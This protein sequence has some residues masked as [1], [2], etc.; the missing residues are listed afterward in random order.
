MNCVRADRVTV[1]TCRRRIST[2][3]DGETWRCERDRYCRRR[4]VAL[5][6]G[7]GVALGTGLG[8]G[9]RDDDAATPAPTPTSVSGLSGA[10][11][12]NALKAALTPRKVTMIPSEGVSTTSSGSS[13]IDG[14]SLVEV[15]PLD[16]SSFSSTS[17]Y[18]TA[19]PAETFVDAVSSEIFRTPNM[20]LCYIA[21]VNWTANLNTGPY[22]AEIDPFHCDNSDGDRIKGKVTY[23]WVVNATGPDI[24]DASDTRDFKTNVWVALSDTPEMPNIDTEMIIKRDDVAIKSDKI[25]VKNFTF[26]YQSPTGSTAPQLIKGVVRRECETTDADSDCTATGVTWWEEVTRGGNSFTAGAKSRAENDVTKASFQTLDFSGGTPQ[27]QSG[28]LVTTATLVKTDAYGQ[29][30]CD[31]LENRSFFGERYGAYDSNGAKVNLQSYVHLQ[32]TGSDGKT[33][34]ADLHYP[35]NLYIFEYDYI[36]DTALSTAEKTIA[37]A[38][39]TDGS[40][41]EEIVDWDDPILNVNKR[42]KVSRGVLYKFT[43]TVRSA[44][45]YQGA[46][47]TSW[48]WDDTNAA[49]VEV[50]FKYD[51]DA[52]AL[53]LSSRRTWNSGSLTANSI[54]SPRTLTM[55]D[56]DNQ[57]IRCWGSIFGRGSA[58]LLNLTHFKVSDA[59]TVPPGSLSSH[60]ALTCGERCIDQTKLSSANSHD[61][62]FYSSPNGYNDARSTYKKFVFNKDTGSLKEDVSGTLSAEV[63]MD[64]TNPFYATNEVHMTLFEATPANLATLSCGTF[65]SEICEEPTKLDVHYEWSSSNWEGMAWL[66][67]PSNSASK[68]F[69]DPPLQLQG[70][71]PTDAV[72]LR[73]PS[74]TDYSGVNL[75]V[76]YEGG[77]VSDAP[78]V[79][80][81]PMTGDR[82]WPEVDSSGDEDCDYTNGYYRRPDVLI[83][84]GTTFKQ[85]STGDRYVLKLESGVEMLTPADASA[86]SGMSYDTSITVP[87]V[88]DY[89]AFTMPTKPSM[90]GLSVKG[91]DKVS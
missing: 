32:A 78:F 59:Q 57:I 39:F 61:S 49:E 80:F 20:V 37:Q 76:R 19:P 27:V 47:I 23:R 67:D 81:N 24:D 34:N 26:T 85:P 7:V 83:P 12:T 55:A 30:F 18:A 63:V 60:L 5:G 33:Y 6:V 87:T 84:D 88:A 11:K 36:S 29:S 70:K 64:P 13:R 65:D 75:N 72:L 22:I 58:S 48:F 68:K 86:C 42:L 89:T 79:C 3:D 44:S 90:T 52:N 2:H 35:G 53:V 8:I 56:I 77:W 16:V 10:A 43:A 21:S 82:K 15:T 28:Q 17:N 40:A 91:T 9:L 4:G 74:G 38:A 73:S 62:Q 45:D 51:S 66:E 46:T 69:M 54:T 25:L 1:A 50:K 71:I 31:E 14:R 41:V